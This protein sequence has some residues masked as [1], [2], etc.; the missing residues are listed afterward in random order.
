MDNP[1]LVSPGMTMTARI[2]WSAVRVISVAKVVYGMHI[3]D[4]PH[5]F[6][7]NVWKKVISVQRRRA[8]MACF[9]MVPL[10][11][12]PRHRAIN[13]FLTCYSQMWLETEEVETKKLIEFLTEEN[14]EED[15]GVGSSVGDSSENLQPS[16]TNGSSA[17]ACGPS[18]AENGDKEEEATEEVDE[19]PDSLKQLVATFSKEATAERAGALPDDDLFMKMAVIMG[20]SCTVGEE[21]EGEEEGG[22]G[23]EPDAE[24]AAKM[25]QE[26]EEAKQQLLSE[27]ARLADRGVAEMVI[28][29][30][31]ASRGEMG[32]MVMTAIE[33]GISLLTGGK[34]VTYFI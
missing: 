14:S 27:Q 6:A 19:K 26:E 32:D 15:S 10:Y 2:S 23:A 3:V 20:K 34:L 8:V 1:N 12:L 5:I 21:D 30:I 33:L 13:L 25:L 18:P 16:I 28:Q 11:V 4:H 7:K 17:A 24:E 29:F 9:R 31:A 22:D